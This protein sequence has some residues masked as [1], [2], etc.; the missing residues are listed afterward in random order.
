MVMIAARK[1]T[2]RNRQNPAALLVI[3]L[4]L[5]V[6]QGDGA[7][8]PFPAHSRLP[9]LKYIAADVAMASQRTAVVSPM[10]AAAN[11]AQA[12]VLSSSFNLAKSIIGMGVLS[13]PSGLAFVTDDRA[14]GN[15]HFP[16][17]VL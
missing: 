5:L 9:T 3:A 13:L 14:A 12:G 17:A 7:T 6:K 11:T 15:M 4:C 2:A 8:R 16:P 10:P 1:S